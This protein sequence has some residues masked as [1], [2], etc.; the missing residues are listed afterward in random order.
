M[1]TTT[2]GSNRSHSSHSRSSERRTHKSEK[3]MPSPKH[4][5]NDRTNVPVIDQRGSQSL[6]NFPFNEEVQRLTSNGTPQRI[7]HGK[8]GGAFGVFEAN[9]DISDICKAK[10]FKK[11]TKT[12]VLVRFSIGCEGNGF[13]DTVREARGFAV[14]MYTEEGIWDFLGSSSPVFLIRSP[15]LFSSLA[16]A[17]K[18]HPQTHGKDPN[19]FW[20]FV[21]N[22]PQTLH[23]ILIVHSDRGMPDGFRHLNGYGSHTFKMVNDRNGFVWVKFHFRCDQNIRNLDPKT[24]GTIAGGQ[25]HYA[26]ADLY[27]A[28]ATKNY[29]SW[30]LYLQVM[31]DEQARSVAFNP[32]D[33]TKIFPH[34]D[35]PLRKVGRLTL[36]ENPTNYTSQIEQAAFN[37]THMPPGI[38]PSPD[39]ILQLRLNSYTDAHRR[40]VGQNDLSI[41]VNNPQTNHN[42]RGNS[43]HQSGFTQTIHGAFDASVFGNYMMLG[44]D[45]FSQPRDFYK[46]GRVN[47]ID[48]IAESLG[49]CTDRNIVHRILVLLS[50]LDVDFGQKM[51]EKIRF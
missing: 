17:Q 37:P 51:A 36:N 24:A 11:G 12:R 33:M 14:K 34:K 45:D 35:F 2:S 26:A 25:L 10:V 32:F 47:L 13:P 3:S 42:F 7:V 21:G 20:N 30:T 28:I 4:S 19:L 43:F 31:T 9:H 22:N 44:E 5:H 39:K 38:E 40:R 29:P 18:R 48:N 16:Q 50:H 15:E 1:S 6:P 27:H 46:Q 41:P 49:Q 23:H 8:G